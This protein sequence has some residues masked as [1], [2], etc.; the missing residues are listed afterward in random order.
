[1]NRFRKRLLAAVVPLAGSAILSA[2]PWAMPAADASTPPPPPVPA[3]ASVLPSSGPI[4]GGTQV[5]IAGTGLGSATAVDFGGNPGSIVSDTATQLVAVTPPGVSTVDVTVTTAGGTSPVSFR[6][7]FGYV[8]LLPTVTSVSPGR[9]LAAGGTQVV[10]LGTNLE[11]AIEIFFGNQVGTIVSD[12]STRI[13]AT[14]PAG[15]GTVDVAVLAPGGIT[16]HVTADHFTYGVASGGGYRV[17]TAQGAVSTFGGLATYSGPTKPAGTSI[18]GVARTAGGYWVALSDGQVLTAGAAQTY[19]AAAL[20]ASLGKVVGIV[21][22][23]DGNGYWLATSAGAVLPY[24][25][26][27]F[28][29]SLQGE[30]LASPIVGIAGDASSGGYLLASAAGNVYNFGTS[31]S[32]PP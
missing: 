22:T 13:V 3:V 17:V 10:V 29:G 21:A 18:A 30:S 19:G 6:D 14:A 28:H 32:G 9:G 2:T 7:R 15:S 31:W 5:T 11:R 1:M 25:D 4:V 27:V 20:P 12:T 8:A 24:G 16:P 23:A 26:A